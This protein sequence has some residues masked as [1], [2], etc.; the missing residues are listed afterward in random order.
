MQDRS[1]VSVLVNRPNFFSG[2][3]IT[4]YLSYKNEIH[5]SLNYSTVFPRL[6]KKKK[7]HGLIYQHDLK[8]PTAILWWKNQY[9]FWDGWLW[10]AALA[11]V[12]AWETRNTC[13]M[14]VLCVLYVLCAARLAELGELFQ[15]RRF[16]FEGLF[17]YCCPPLTLPYPPFLICPTVPGPQLWL[18]CVIN[19]SLTGTSEV[20]SCCFS[21]DD[22]ACITQL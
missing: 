6:V 8:T 5:S 3:N 22:P 13:L 14:H 12:C 21:S 19:T 18:H 1:D 17:C 2:I 9:R 16:Y 4:S 7:T 20:P 11:C 10:Q 15:A